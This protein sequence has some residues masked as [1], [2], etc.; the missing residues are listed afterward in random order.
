M[1]SSMGMPQAEPILKEYL[2]NQNACSWLFKV[3]TA[4]IYAE[5][6]GIC[7]FLLQMISK[8]FQFRF[9]KIIIVICCMNAG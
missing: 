8:K 5:K 9:P 4:K 3:S 1:C 7:S 6:A 2:I